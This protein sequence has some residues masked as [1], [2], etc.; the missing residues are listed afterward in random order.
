MNSKVITSFGTAFIDEK[1][2]LYNEIESIGQI[3]AN[4]GYKV[5]SGGYYGSMEA[6]SKGAKNG[7]GST[8]GI[9]VKD[10]K[11]LPNKYID[12]IAVMPNLM[13]RIVELI[14]I[15]DMYIVFKGGTGTLVEIS[16]ALE[17]M[18]KKIIPEK[19]MIF[20]T[21]FW[22]NMTDILKQDSDGLR[23]LIDRNIVFINKPEDL[24]QN[25]I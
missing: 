6:I 7:N 8:I 13:E 21:E 3:I 10:W 12:E 24:R 22:K 9:T 20:Y 15:A 16:V 19:R 14:G 25:L 18:N 2:A 23:S 11:Q 4:A 5:C 1:D 17:L